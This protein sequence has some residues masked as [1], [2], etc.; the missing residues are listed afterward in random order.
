MNRLIGL[1]LLTAI[2]GLAQDSGGQWWRKAVFY[3]IYP[4]SFQDTNGDG[5]GDLKGIT[6]RL[7]YLAELGIDA[8]WIT[9]FSPSPQ[10]DFGYDV[11]DYE[12]VDPQ[13][14]TLADFDKLVA[15]AHKRKI[16]IIMD[17]VL[18]HTSDQ[19]EFFKQSRSSRD[20]P[21]RDWYIWRDGKDGGPPNNWSSEFGPTAWTLDEK[22]G[23][24]YYHYFYTQQPDL[25]WRN[26]EVEK[27]MF[28]SVRFWLKRGA[29]GFRLDAINWLFEDPEWR[30]NPML[31]DFRRGSKTEHQQEVK[32]N[33]DQP[34]THDVLRRLR[35]VAAEFGPDRVLIGEIWVPSMTQL[36]EYYGVNN[37]E[38]QLPF[39]FFF[40]QVP[41]LDAALFRAEVDKAEKALKGR[42]TTWVL[43]NHDLV[44]AVNRFGDGRNDKKIEKLLATMLLTLRGSPFIYYGEELGMVTT[45]PKSRDEVRDPVGKLYWPNEKGR[46]GERTPMQ[47]TS[48]RNAGFTTGQP[49]LPV[50]PSAGK[51]NVAAEESDPTSVL[52]YYKRMIAVRRASPALLSGDYT[53]LGDDP[54]VFAYRRH[55]EGQTYVIALNM[56]P[57]EHKVSLGKPLAPSGKLVLDTDGPD[58]GTVELWDLHLRPY[59]ALVILIP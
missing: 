3:E 9:P 11:S 5:I 30:D 43:S 44:R 58:H 18:N 31:P 21:Y 48:G 41:K 26:P 51:N 36:T 4:R 56:S 54:H 52:N 38:L 24:Y 57:E 17:L 34:E 28:D 32:Y 25:N 13:F 6:Q 14:G 53:P 33:R 27:R 16:R 10:V 20:S 59:E 2:G 47:W 29:D 23:Q 37:D 12:N 45:P 19:S 55:A 40:T 8:I 15:E 50:P 46:D 35:Q 42:W 1:L 49:W 22:T 39:N 7:P